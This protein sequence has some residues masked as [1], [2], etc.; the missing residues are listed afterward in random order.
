MKPTL[1]HVYLVDDD[2]DVRLF[3]GNLLHLLGYSV[4]VYED[5]DSFLSR[6]VDIA[7][8][9]LLLDMRMPGLSGLQAMGLLRALGRTT[10]VVFISGD[11][12]SQEIIDA[13]KGGATD[14]LC[15]PFTKEQ[16]IVAVNLGLQRDSAAHQDAKRQEALRRRYGTLTEREREVFGL[17]LMGHPNKTIGLITGIQAGTAKKHRAGVFAKMGVSSTAE[18]ITTCRGIRLQELDMP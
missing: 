9:V 12:R 13:M 6:S 8:A 10:P 17:I 18:L 1:G 16:L 15:K 4:D 7:P 3:L 5:A 11:S 2:P 14:F